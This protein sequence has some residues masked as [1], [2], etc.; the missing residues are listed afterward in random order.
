MAR[1]D[2]LI[3][4]YELEAA[5]A[6]RRAVVHRLQIFAEQHQLLTERLQPAHDLL[7]SALQ[8]AH[9]R[10]VWATTRRRGSWY[11]LD[12]FYYLG[13]GAASEAKRRSDPAFGALNGLLE[14]MLGDFEFETARGFVGEVQ[15]Q[16][17]EWREKFIQ[18]TRHAGEETFRPAL[19]DAS[20]LW[21]KC[22]IRWGRGPGYRKDVAEAMRD[23]FA[24]PA[25]DHLH[26]ALEVRVKTAWESEVLQPLRA[27]CDGTS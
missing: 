8:T 14:N 13:A 27:L 21:S 1:V 2:G 22:E 11:N 4:N 6:V 16:A 24:E 26:R 20:D 3:A 9:A 23:W 10:T 25:R 15:V 12:V 5:A 7:Y 19:Q 17:G 18:A